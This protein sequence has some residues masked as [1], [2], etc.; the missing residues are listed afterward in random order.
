MIG[1]LF[2]TTA[3]LLSAP[4]LLPPLPTPPPTLTPVPRAPPN[5][6]RHCA[7]AEVFLPK[8]PLCIPGGLLPP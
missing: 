6:N 3:V 2:Y 4:P 5:H 1:A 7:I 8:F